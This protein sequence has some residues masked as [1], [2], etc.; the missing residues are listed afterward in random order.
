MAEL[1]SG[2]V[3]VKRGRMKEL[4]T[5]KQVQSQPTLGGELDA[6][7][8]EHHGVS[9]DTTPSWLEELILG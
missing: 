5:C 4:H 8:G 7:G 9:L 6:E 3:A 1:S 2:K